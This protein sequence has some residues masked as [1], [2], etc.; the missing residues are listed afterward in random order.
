MTDV[1]L[2]LYFLFTLVSLLSLVSPKADRPA[3][4]FL[5]IPVSI[6]RLFFSGACVSSAKEREPPGPICR[7]VKR[8][9]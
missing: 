9:T 6:H 2:S 5:F 1:S 7:Y 8:R 3:T 4:P